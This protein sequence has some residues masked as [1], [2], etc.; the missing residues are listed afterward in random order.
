MAATDAFSTAY[1]DFWQDQYDCVD[2]IILNAYFQMGC[3]PGG[4]RNW[5]R[6]LYGNDDN[7]DNNHLMR[8]AGR[9]SRT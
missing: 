4:F 5:W 6:A 1:A 7:L 8:L 9:F 3:S 2:R